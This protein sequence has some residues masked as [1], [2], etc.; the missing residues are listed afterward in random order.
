MVLRSVAKN[1]AKEVASTAKDNYNRTVIDKLRDYLLVAAITVVAVLV[2]LRLTPSFPL[3]IS[4]RSL[5]KE[6]T[7]QVTGE[8][9]VFVKPDVAEISFSTQIEG[10]TVKDVQS[11]ANEIINRATAQLKKLGLKDEEM[12]TTNYNLTPKYR[13]DFGRQTLDGY[14]ANLTLQIRVKDFAQLNEAVDAAVAAGV[15]QVGNLTFSVE[16]REKFVQQARVKATQEAQRKAQ[17]LAGAAGMKLGRIT[18]IT[19]NAPTPPPIYL[20]TAELGAPAAGQQTQ[21]Q[22]GENEIRVSVTLFYETL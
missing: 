8:G 16:D 11:R 19:E 21:I 18:N 3:I 13:Y 5:D 22:P 20:R 7:F 12:K 6:T 17:A 9:I 10:T 14:F 2:F 4:T 1:F 15:N